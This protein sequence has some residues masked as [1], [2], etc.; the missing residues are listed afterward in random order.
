M[1][2]GVNAMQSLLNIVVFK[3]L[4]YIYGKTVLS[5]GK[6]DNTISFGDHCGP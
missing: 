5:G 1:Y 3:S 2:T 4:T 6:S